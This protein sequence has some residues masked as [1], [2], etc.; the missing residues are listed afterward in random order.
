M[1]VSES[2]KP[3]P[4]RTFAELGRL[5]RALPGPDM[6]AAGKAKAR[7]PNLTK[8]PG[9]LGRLEEIAEWLAAWQG[10]HPPK[11]EKPAARIFA[12]NHGVTAQGVSAY[13]PDVT[14][15]MVG[16]FKA[17]GAA[18]NQLCRAFGADLRVKALN[19]ATPTAD[20]TQGPA[21]TEAE[22][23]AAIRAGMASVPKRAD[24]LCLGE[25]GIGN[26]TAA[27]ALCLALFGGK[28]TDW[29]GPGTGVKGKALSRK[30]QVVAAAVKRHR[31]VK[32]PLDLVACL[33]GRELA[34]IVGAALE[35]RRRRIPVL[36]DGYVCTAAVAVLPFVR[37]DAL[38]HCLVAHASAEPG[39]R[40]LIQKIG[41][42][43]LL[44][45]NMRLGEASGAVLAIA[46]LEA[47]A[48]CHGGMATFAEAGVSGKDA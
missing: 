39:H 26:T 38:D 16:N 23:M 15:Q 37:A 33:G 44:D 21:M 13:P 46:I 4:P 2:R 14:A 25:M 10:R 20:F 45:L 27:A 29:T 47:A 43:P 34:A 9:A 32:S 18:V 12:A 35:A 28:A 7:E 17:G 22:C 3:K 42:A 48:A 5:I 19:L 6:R 40:R 41:K 24:V 11:V 30:A 8:P 1:P 31:K 36:L